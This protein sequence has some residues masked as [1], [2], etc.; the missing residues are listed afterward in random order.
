MTGRSGLSSRLGGRILPLEGKAL[1]SSSEAGLAGEGQPSCCGEDC[2]V[3]AM[4]T[5]VLSDTGPSP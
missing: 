4:V 2:P 5:A 3:L 1:S